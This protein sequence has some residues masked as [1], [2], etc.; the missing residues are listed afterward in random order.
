MD[1][2]RQ[3]DPA[4]IPRLI[5]QLEE[6]DL[7]VVSGWRRKRRDSLGK[8]LSSLAARRLRRLLINDGIHDSGCTLKVYRAE[9]FHGIN[10]YGEMHRFI[11]AVLKIKGFKVGEL[12]VNH[13]PASP[14]ARSTAGSVV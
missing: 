2:D 1:G 4:D 5:A 14:G 11:P 9:C 3:N 8:R 12:E 10:L 13:R 7:D 6:R